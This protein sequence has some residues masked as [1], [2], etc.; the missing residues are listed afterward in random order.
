[1]PA[2]HIQW[3]RNKIEP[4]LT[5][6]GMTVGDGIFDFLPAGSI[7]VEP[8]SGAGLFAVDKLM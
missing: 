2:H 5:S 7:Q 4:D 6:G 8:E 1:M 3:Q